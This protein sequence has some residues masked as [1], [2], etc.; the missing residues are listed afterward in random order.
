MSLRDKLERYRKHNAPAGKNKVM[1]VDDDIKQR[2]LLA[3]FLGSH[4][5]LCIC[6]DGYSAIKSY[7]SSIDVV[8]LDI[9]MEGMDGTDTLQQLRRMNPESKIILY[10]GYTETDMHSIV[11]K[12]RPNDVHYKTESI[13]LLLKKIEEVLNV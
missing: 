11:E 4:Y 13:D 1:I 10:T 9:K 3:D 5:K 12:Y 6:N 2:N 7:D 8:I